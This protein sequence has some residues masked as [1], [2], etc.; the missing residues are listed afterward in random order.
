MTVE[1]LISWPTIEQSL[2][3]KLGL[4]TFLSSFMSKPINAELMSLFA[5][6]EFRMIDSK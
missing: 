2:I 5:T 4:F 6:F 1:C 3:F